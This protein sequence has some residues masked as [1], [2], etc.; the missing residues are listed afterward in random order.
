MCYNLLSDYFIKEG[1]QNNNICLCVFIKSS[2]NEFVVIAV[3]VDNLNL[4]GT[5]NEIARV[6]S[7]LRKEF[8]MKDL[9]KT[10]FCLGI[11]IE[12]LFTGIFIHQSTYTEKMLKTFNID[13]AYSL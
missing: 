1:Y 11:Q 10:K 6:A 7:Y 9:G 4:V 8:E 13:K 2:T 3:Y 5:P 12:H